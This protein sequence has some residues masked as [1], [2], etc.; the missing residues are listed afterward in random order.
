[1][2]G[3]IAVFSEQKC[4]ITKFECV[5]K[6]LN[7]SLNFGKTWGNEKKKSTLIISL[8]KGQMGKARW[9]IKSVQDGLGSAGFTVELKDLKDPFQSQ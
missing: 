1:M 2:T 8:L 7:P 9:Q 6:L 4:V 3:K 5:K